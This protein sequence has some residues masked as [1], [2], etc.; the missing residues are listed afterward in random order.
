MAAA[1]A[2][3]GAAFWLYLHQNPIGSPLFGVASDTLPAALAGV[4]AVLGAALVV[5]LVLRNPPVAPAGTTDG[6]AG[7]LRLLGLI[8]LCVG[9]SASLRHVGFL[10]A[11]G[12]LALGTALLFG[13]RQVVALAVLALAVPFGIAF[14]FEKAMVIYLPTGSLFQ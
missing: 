10:V 9:F 3:T 5:V 14:F 4:I 6:I 11:G 1:L 12:G 7:L 8:V 13:K 2:A